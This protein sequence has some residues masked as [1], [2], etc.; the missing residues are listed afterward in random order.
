M[1]SKHR[2]V[3]SGL[4]DPQLLEPLRGLLLPQLPASS[5]AY[6]RGVSEGA[7]VLV[8]NDTGATWTAVT[9]AIL[10]K[11][12]HSKTLGQRHG[13]VAQRM[14]RKQS[15]VLRFL[16][17]GCAK[18]VQ[19]LTWKPLAPPPEPS[20]YGIGKAPCQQVSIG[21]SPCS[22]WVS[23]QLLATAHNTVKVY[24]TSRVVAIDPLQACSGLSS[25]WSVLW[26]EWLKVEG[27]LLLAI[28]KG[29]GH[30][31][32]YTLIHYDAWTETASSVDERRS[33]PPLTLS[34]QLDALTWQSSQRCADVLQL[35]T[36][37]TVSIIAGRADETCDCNAFSHD[38]AYLAVCWSAADSA[39]AS[40]RAAIYSVSTA[41]ELQS[42]SCSSCGP[43]T[44]SIEWSPTAAILAVHAAEEGFLLNLE[45][46]SQLQVPQLAT[47]RRSMTNSFMAWAPDGSFLM[48][49]GHD[50]HE[51]AAATSQPLCWLI[52][53]NGDGVGNWS[54]PVL[55]QPPAAEEDEGDEYSIP[56]PSSYDSMTDWEESSVNQ[57][58][59]CPFEPLWSAGIP[60]VIKPRDF[61][62]VQML[63]A[64][65]PR[66]TLSLGLPERSSY[67]PDCNIFI[68]FPSTDGPCS[69]LMQHQLHVPS[70]S[71][72]SSLIQ[73][74]ERFARFA[75]LQPQKHPCPVYDTYAVALAN[76][77]IVLIDGLRQKVWMVW[78]SCALA[79]HIKANEREDSWRKRPC[80][81]VWSSLQWSPD[82]SQ[83][84]CTGPHQIVAIRFWADWQRKMVG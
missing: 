49:Q 43:N 22:R 21:W 44:I 48:V 31:Q 54:M 17:H 46:N 74:L 34:P 23:V 36:M 2:S 73:G 30:E 57:H 10:A 24:D 5:L 45:T 80:A 64:H 53:P 56:S 50:S 4:L 68:E 82:G 12:L 37:Q 15:P 20:A 38:T 59:Q 78:K 77:D 60:G 55:Q 72:S 42:I 28:C 62:I 58:G 25:L 13:Y 16:K 29:K 66:L 27:S 47:S 41:A 61:Q 18:D 33:S 1:K 35:P 19:L 70:W 83:L 9:E 79:G 40:Q 65:N 51:I 84:F 3:G 69:C 71:T 76:G 14:L 52:A 32:E 67:L 7:Q 39:G 8:D 81:P 26:L 63:F 11:Q 75:E 6:L